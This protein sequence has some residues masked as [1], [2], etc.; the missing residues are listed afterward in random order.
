MYGDIGHGT[1]LFLFAL[2]LCI[3]EKSLSKSARENEMLGAILGGRYLLLLMG[4]F[5]IYVGLM[6]NDCMSV[7]LNLFGSQYS[8]TEGSDL[9]TKVAGASVYPF[10]VDP[11]FLYFDLLYNERHGM[12]Q[13]LNWLFIIP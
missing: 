6:Y 12:V 3:Y 4:A 8:F 9:A 13:P 7:S 1:C 2:Y 10:G 11:V 5:A